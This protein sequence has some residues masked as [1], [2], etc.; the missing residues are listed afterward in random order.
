MEEEIIRVLGQQVKAGKTTW[1]EAAKKF[2]EQTGEKINKEA[3]RKRYERKNDNKSFEVVKKND[4]NEEFETHYQNGNIDIQRK[5]W[6]DEGE[7]KTPEV[8]LKKFGYSPDEWVLTEF[9]FGSWEVAIGS[10]SNN[11]VCTT[12]RAKIK[13]FVKES[14]TVEE[15]M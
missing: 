15:Y 11:R 8:V 5:I 13:P 1:A 7:E 2:E 14:L 12:V 9:R 4:K 10:E 6:F 3:F